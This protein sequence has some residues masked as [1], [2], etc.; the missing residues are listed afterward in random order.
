MELPAQSPAVPSTP[1]QMGF[2]TPGQS[3]RGAE[4]QPGSQ[5]K[6]ALPAWTSALWGKEGKNAHFDLFLHLELY[7]LQC[8]S[9]LVPFGPVKGLWTGRQPL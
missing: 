9:P 8:T 5:E 3:S 4:T 6:P 7:V 1:M 2:S